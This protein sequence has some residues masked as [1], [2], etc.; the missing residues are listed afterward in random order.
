MHLA[1]GWFACFMLVFLA[2]YASGIVSSTVRPG[3][4]TL[5]LFPCFICEE[6][7]R[8]KHNDG[9][10]S[11]EELIERD[12]EEG[13]LAVEEMDDQLSTIKSNVWKKPQKDIHALKSD[14]EQLRDAVQNSTITLE[15]AEAQLK[16]LKSKYD[17]IT[18]ERET[19]ERSALKSWV[20]LPTMRH[21]LLRFEARLLDDDIYG[22]NQSQIA[23]IDKMR[24][25]MNDVAMQLRAV[26]EYYFISD[27]DL[28]NAGVVLS[29]AESELLKRRALL[30]TEKPKQKCFWFFCI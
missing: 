17:A 7:Q 26:Y 14:I 10:E 5:Q 18:L 27:D 24:S 12:E 13:F 16:S 3:V 4:K 15:D 23:R 22:K 11:L 28:L 6:Q 8:Y 2:T 1:Y 30:P 9:D 19:N 21:R 29:E 20:Q 25:T